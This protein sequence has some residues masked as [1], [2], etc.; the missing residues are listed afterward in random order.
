MF[1]WVISTPLGHEV[2]PEVN[3]II[4]VSW[5]SSSHG[6]T[7]TSPH[8]LTAASKSTAAATSPSPPLWETST[9]SMG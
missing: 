5:P 8:A 3:M 9:R 7:S 4:A 2:V 1:A 6:S